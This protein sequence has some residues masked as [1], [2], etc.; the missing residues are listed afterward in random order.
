MPTAATCPKCKAKY[1]LPD[2]L[3]GKPVKCKSC[4]TMFKVAAP[5]AARAA[6]QP[7]RKPVAA[8]PQANQA[9]LAQL[10]LD[11][12]ITRQPELFGEIPPPQAGNP[13]GNHVVVDPGFGEVEASVV[14]EKEAKEAVAAIF[15]NPALEQKAKPVAKKSNKKKRSLI[16][17]D[18]EKKSSNQMLLLF[19]LA[20]VLS[21]VATISTPMMFRIST[22][23][24]IY[25]FGVMP[26]MGVVS[27]AVTVWWLFRC[28]QSRTTVGNFLLILIPFYIFVYSF[29]R[30]KLPWTKEPL[31]CW[32]V[33]FV[34][35][36]GVYFAAHFM[37][38]L[39]QWQKL[40]EA[41]VM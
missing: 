39:E 19:S 36:I 4:N 20:I 1:S 15:R 25:V 9:E 32:L 34:G 33:V 5:K 40:K 30:D 23:V 38:I 17:S 12:P 2:Q 29:N 24:K 26:F 41:G 11:G 3:L 27:L 37:G 16:T 18:D 22:A 31:I 28:W 14:A 21:L 35:S 7:A 8:I 10:G 6:K 13:L